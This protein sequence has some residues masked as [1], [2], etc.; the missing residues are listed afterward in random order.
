MSRTQKNRP[1]IEKLRRE[2]ELLRKE[3]KTLTERIGET[4]EF[5]DANLNKFIMK[6]K[7]LIAGEREKAIK[8]LNSY[9]TR[10]RTFIRRFLGWFGI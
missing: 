5:N 7:G 3:I 4:L 10:E 6:A 9:Q 1:D 8:I 2:I